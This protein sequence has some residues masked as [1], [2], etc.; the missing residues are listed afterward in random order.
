MRDGASGSQRLARRLPRSSGSA[1]AGCRSWAGGGGLAGV[2]VGSGPGPGLVRDGTAC[3]RDGGDALRGG[4]DC[5]VGSGQWAEPPQYLPALSWGV[6]GGQDG[7][8]RAH[9]GAD[10]TNRQ[11]ASRYALPMSYSSQWAAIDQP[12]R[13]SASPRRTKASAAVSAERARQYL[14]TSRGMP[15]MGFARCMSHRDMIC[16]AGRIVRALATA[17]AR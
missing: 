11:G 10:C 4:A 7:R 13:L 17:L 16:N 5:A 2:G 12:V 15:T 3:G 6:L 14:D 8:R 1:A 9:P